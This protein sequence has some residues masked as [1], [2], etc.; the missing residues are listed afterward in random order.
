[1]K[2]ISI[3][4]T[5]Q[6]QYRQATPGITRSQAMKTAWAAVKENPTVEVVTFTKKD[7]TKTT[8]VVTRNWTKFQEPKGS[9]RSAKEGQIIAADLVKYLTGSP[10][11]ISFYEN[12]VVPV[13]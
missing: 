10:C 12:A 9:G 3:V 11:I 1:M 2:Q 6:A 7:N 4:N 13:A 8:R 5:L